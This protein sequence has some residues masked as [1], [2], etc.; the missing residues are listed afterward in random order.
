MVFSLWNGGPQVLA[1][2]A[3]HSSVPSSMLDTV[4]RLVDMYST[5][6]APAAINTV[7]V[8]GPERIGKSYVLAKLLKHLTG[9]DSD[10]NA[11]EAVTAVWQDPP[12]GWDTPEV[13]GL[14]QAETPGL[15]SVGIFTEAG[16][17]SPWAPGGYGAM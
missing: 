1:G 2:V 12:E 14:P 15:R 17:E 10:A 8:A 5:A 16:S 3:D 6:A 11:A 4:S 7:I 9:L 13:N